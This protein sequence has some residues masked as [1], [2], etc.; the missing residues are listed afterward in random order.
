MKK[1]EKSICGLFPYLWPGSYRKNDMLTYAEQFLL[2]TIDPVTGKSF[3]LPQKVYSL[4]LAGAL[5]FDASFKGLINDDWKN[6]TLLDT[7]ET[8][9]PALD[10][11]L[12][13]LLVMDGP[14]P[15]DNALTLVATHALTLGRMVWDSLQ[16][17]GLLVRRKKD[18]IFSTRKQDLFSPDLPLVVDLHRQIREA[19]RHDELPDIH[20]PALVSLLVAGGLMKYILNAEEAGSYRTRISWLAGIESLGREIIRSVRALEFADLEQNAA[21]LIGLNANEPKSFAGGMDSVLSSLG[22][23]YKE[24]GMRGTRKIMAH[25]NQEGG[26]ECPGCSWPNPDKNRSHFEFCESGAKNVSAEATS[27]RITPDFFKAWS[28]QELLLT[29]GFWM[30]QQGRLTEPMFLDENETHYKPISWDEAFR[31]IAAE[32]NGLDHPDEAVFYAS[33]RTSNEA[34]FL[35]Q[36]FARTFGTNNLPSSANLCHEPSGKA[37]AMSLGYGK[38]S[39]TPDDFPKADAIFIFGHN[40]GSNHPRM[41]KSLLEAVQNGCRIVAVNPMPEASLMGFADPQLASSWFGKQT[42]LAHVYL[43]P[44]ING[45]MAL[46]RGMVKAILE[47]ENRDGGI[48]DTL[49][50]RNY[51]SGFETYRQTVLNTPWESLV[52]ASGVEKFQMVE[53]ANVY[54][55]AKNVIASWCL[56]IAH[57]LNSVDTIREI[58]NLLLLRGNIG[59]PG[60]GVCPVRGHSNIQGIRTSGMGENLSPSFLDAMEQ[61]FSVTLPRK[62]GMGMVPAIKA[63]AAGKTKVLISLGGNLASALPDTAFVEQALQ[64]CRLSVMISTKLNRSHLV[65]GKKALILPCLSRSEEDVCNGMKQ[66]I[67]IES[68]MGKVEFSTGC[69]PPASTGLKSEI[70]IIAGIANSTLG[71][72]PQI[73]WPR[74]GHD[75][76][77]IRSVIS[78]IIPVFRELD[79]ETAVNHGFHI[80][81]PLKQRIFKTRDSKAQFS[82]HPIEMVV[83]GTGELMLMTI[84]S[85]DQFNTSVF[86]LNDRYRGIGNERRVLFMNRIDMEERTLISGQLVDIISH[87]DEKERK[88][89]GYYA[90]AYPIKQGCVAAYFPEANSLISINNSSDECPTPAYKSVRVKV[91]QSVDS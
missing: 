17:Q 90:M 84:R 13:C 51:T 15:L 85:H 29:S 4:S 91:I 34:A 81:N 49:F 68:A 80:E 5:L 24:A 7:E 37:L 71:H 78:Q 86:G 36:L 66:K 44:V 6:L 88:L 26:F 42:A 61:Y 53:A 1:F 59:K 54:I 69:L 35:Y 50:I 89:E 43:Q 55:H 77:L 10:E 83:P 21:S 87:Y 74:F 9:N 65:T 62:P 31:V 79:K 20:I 48:L 39:V 27:M 73:D 63:M 46:I 2:L 75:Y 16:N 41:L 82:S 23:L 70:T 58:I 40:P 45:D 3:P 14:I 64:R 72:N 8:G 19:L 38:S 28:V 33:G 18:L 47:A 11:T 12:R 67:S 76:Q 60:A 22:Y 25:L 52:S 56:G 57:H 30:E 32:L